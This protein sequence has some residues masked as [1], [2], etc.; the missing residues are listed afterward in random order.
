MLGQFTRPGM[1]RMVK[2]LRL[3]R[4]AKFLHA[5]PELTIIVKGINLATRSVSDW[6]QPGEGEMAATPTGP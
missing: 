3:S 6:H 4:M 5:V 1:F 2:L